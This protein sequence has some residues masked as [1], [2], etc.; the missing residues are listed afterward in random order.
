[1]HSSPLCNVCVASDGR[2][3]QH[4]VKRKPTHAHSFMH[5]HT[6][7]TLGPN[8]AID[9]NH[10]WVLHRVSRKQ[11]QKRRSHHAIRFNSISSIQSIPPS[12]HPFRHNTDTDGKKK[13]KT[14][15]M[16]TRFVV[17]RSPPSTYGKPKLPSEQ[18]KNK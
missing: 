11:K 12:I 14:Q 13:K 18:P 6:L 2:R 3:Q 7:R 17:T 4:T 5:T 10:Q 1:M 16:N 9:E 15:E 8:L